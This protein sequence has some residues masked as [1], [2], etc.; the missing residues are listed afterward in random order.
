MKP[1]HLLVI[2]GPQGSGKSLRATQAVG[3]RRASYVEGARLMRT[4]FGW[5]MALRGDPEVLVIEGPID[6][7][8]L[9]TVVDAG[10]LEVYVRLQPPRTAVLPALILCCDT[11][12]AAAYENH[13]RVTIV[14]LP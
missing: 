2:A 13:P 6:P 4:V 14:R 3:W 12:D 10:S 9:L 5:G 7:Q 11:S 8:S 1:G